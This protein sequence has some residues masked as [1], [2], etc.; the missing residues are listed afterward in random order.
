MRSH[1]FWHNRDAS[2]LK[3]AGK[4]FLIVTGILLLAA[5]LGYLIMLLWNL[6]VAAIFD[7]PTITYWQAVGLFLLAKMFMGFGGG[8]RHSKSKHRN[9]HIR[10]Q[11]TDTEDVSNLAADTMFKEFWQGEGKQA[12]EAYREARQQNQA[13]GPEES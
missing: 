6:T 13:S 9:K 3:K 11:S 8:H 7:V 4:I 2:K 1:N 10:H 12:Y 5:L